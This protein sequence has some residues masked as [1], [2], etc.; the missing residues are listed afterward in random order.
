MPSLRLIT[1]LSFICLLFVYFL[2]QVR[3]A[4]AS[5]SGGCDH[6]LYHDAVVTG[7]ESAAQRRAADGACCSWALSGAGPGHRPV[8][9]APSCK[10]LSILRRDELMDS[11]LLVFVCLCAHLCLLAC[12]FIGLFWPD[13]EQTLGVEGV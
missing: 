3:Y 2:L 8:H 13:F 5:E 1:V 10:L 4:V 6:E 7:Q 12:L 9:F 11:C